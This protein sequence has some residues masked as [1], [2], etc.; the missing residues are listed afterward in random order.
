MEESDGGILKTVQYVVYTVNGPTLS[1]ILALREMG[2]LGKR[3]KTS[4]VAEVQ[5]NKTAPIFYMGKNKAQLSTVANETLQ[6]I[7]ETRQ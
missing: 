7:A 6:K 5:R 1:F 3:P 2:I 4:D